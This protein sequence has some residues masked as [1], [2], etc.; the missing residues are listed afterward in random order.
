MASDQTSSRRLFPKLTVVDLQDNQSQEAILIRERKRVD[1]QAVKRIVDTEV[2]ELRLQLQQAIQAAKEGHQLIAMAEWS[3][4][5]P[6]QLDALRLLLGRLAETA[7][8]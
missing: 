3:D 2:Q 7:S 8:Q 1:R 4:S 6:G 5:D